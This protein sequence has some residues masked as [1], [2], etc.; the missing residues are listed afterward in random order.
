MTERPTRVQLRC[1]NCGGVIGSLPQ[2]SSLDVSLICPNCGT[3]VKPPSMLERIVAK[4]TGLIGRLT[5]R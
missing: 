3:I 1:S 4:V 5:S 2:G